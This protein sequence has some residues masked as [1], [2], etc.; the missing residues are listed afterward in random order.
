MK[1]VF[2]KALLNRA[3]DLSP[4]ERI[5]YSFLIS[6][7]VTYISDFFD[8]DGTCL[9]VEELYSYLEVCKYIELFPISTRRLA[10]VLHITHPT[11]ING[12]K[13][14]RKLGYIQNSDIFV[15]KEYLEYGFF[16]LHRYDILTGQVLIFYSFIKDKARLYGGCIDTFRIKL[17]ELFDVAIYSINQYL[18]KLYKLN[19]IKRLDNNKLLVL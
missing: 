3:K 10:E 12:L 15:D 2:Y 4:T 19:L 17:A 7:S 9:N 8:V 14:M 16:E 13:K 11:V 1:I 6:K 18:A 5:I